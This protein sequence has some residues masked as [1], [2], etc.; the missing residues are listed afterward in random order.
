MCVCVYMYLNIYD[1]LTWARNDSR[2]NALSIIR[3]AGVS[4]SGNVATT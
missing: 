3:R 2:P 4:W 1:V